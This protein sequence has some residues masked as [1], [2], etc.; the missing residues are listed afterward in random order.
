MYR[1]WKTQRSASAASEN[2]IES[3]NCVNSV[4]TVNTV[5]TVD[6]SQCCRCKN[7]PQLVSATSEPEP[8]RCSEAE[9]AS[10]PK[11]KESIPICINFP[12]LK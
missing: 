7:K 1:R 12:F 5:N 6:Q 11:V 9:Q 3:E 10:S 4:N 8:A 2:H